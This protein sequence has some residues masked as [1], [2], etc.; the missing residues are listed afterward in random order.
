M[1][2]SQ[3]HSAAAMQAIAGDFIKIPNPPGG[4]INNTYN[5]AAY[6]TT[7]LIAPDR[8]IVSQDIWPISSTILRN[9]VEG[10]GGI[11]S[12]CDPIEPDEIDAELLSIVSPISF[13]GEPQDIVPVVTIRNNGTENLSEADVSYVLNSGDPVVVNWTGNLATGETTDVS[14]DQIGLVNGN[15]VF[16]ATITV[17]G[18]ANPDNNSMT[19]NFT[20]ADCSDSPDI[21]FNEIFNSADLPGCW[22]VQNQHPTHTWASTTGYTIGEINITPQTG[23]HFWYVNWSYSQNQD[24]WLISPSFNFSDILN[25]QISFWFNGNYHWS[26]DPEDNCDLHLMFSVNGGEWTE[27]WNETDHPDFTSTDLSYVWLETII[28]LGD[29]AG[30]ADFKFAFRYIG[31][32]GAQFAVDNIS[33]TDETTSICRKNLSNNISIFPNPA[34]THI[35]IGLNEGLEQMTN[36]NIYNQ[37]GQE[38][39]SGRIDSE[40]TEIS[41]KELAEGLYFLNITNADGVIISNQKFIKK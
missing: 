17:A 24:E 3:D 15:H 6:P 11:P 31:F 35:I 39:M 9:E 36:F 26:V 38:L 13:Y 12:S 22:I 30:V 2:I 41:V 14:F 4:T 18:D 37:L 40:Y 28:N 20:V 27:V 21:P 7:I 34:E 19:R 10:A 1:S 23:S 5:P 33:I 32:D 8:S 16:V 25:P 29:Y